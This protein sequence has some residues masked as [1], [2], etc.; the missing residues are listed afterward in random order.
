MTIKHWPASDRPREKLLALGAEAL[1]DAELLAIF[2]RTGCQ[3]RSAVDVA[4]L[5]LSEF[6]SLR[7]LLGASKAQFCAQKGLGSA[8]YVQLQPI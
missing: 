3:G 6:G 1:S 5:L 4:R 8:K 2:L 7:A